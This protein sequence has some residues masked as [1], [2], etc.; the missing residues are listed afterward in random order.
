MNDLKNQASSG[1]ITLSGSA[2]KLGVGF[3]GLPFVALNLEYIMNDYNKYK[4]PGVDQS[5]D[6]SGYLKDA[7]MNSILFSLSVPFDI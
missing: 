6:S 2:L 4:S 1:D 7:K 5:I 3:T